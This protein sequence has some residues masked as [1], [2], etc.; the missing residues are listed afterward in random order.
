MGDQGHGRS[1]FGRRA[2]IGLITLTLMAGVM[3]MTGVVME[4]VARQDVMAYLTMYGKKPI[5]LRFEG[6]RHSFTHVAW[7]KYSVSGDSQVSRAFWRLVPFRRVD[8]EK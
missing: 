4:R 7:F 6:L 3:L 1:H 2:R 8:L 5:T